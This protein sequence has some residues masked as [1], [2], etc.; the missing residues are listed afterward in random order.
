[1]RKVAVLIF[2]LFLAVFSG[3]ALLG[4]GGGNNSTT[5]P[6]P[7][8]SVNVIP[9]SLSLTPGQVAAVTARPLDADGNA[10]FANSVTFASANTALVQV[11]KNGL[12]CAGSWDS[13]DS[14]VVCTPAASPVGQTTITATADMVT[15]A[16]VPV[17][18]HVVIDNITV[19]PTAVDCR[20]QDDTQ[21][22]TATVF[23]GG[24]DITSTVGP[25]TWSSSLTPQ[26]TIDEDGLATAELPGRSNITASVGGTTSPAAPFTVCPPASISLHVSGAPDTS[27][28]IAT[29]ANRDLAVDVVDTLGQTVTGLPIALVSSSPAVATVSVA[30]SGS[31]VTLRATGAAP[32]TAILTAHC[33]PPAC[34][35]NTT[36]A[37]YSNAVTATVT[38]TAGAGRVYATCTSTSAPCTT[39][40]S[41]GGTQTPLVPIDTST[42]TA[43]TVVNLP[44]TP[45][46]MVFSRDGTLMLLG[47]AN[48]LMQVDA[49]TN[50]IADTITNAQGRVLAVSPDAN[51]V[52]IFDGSANQLRI[53]DRNASTVT[54]ASFTGITGAAFTPDGFKLFLVAGNTLHVISDVSVPQAIPLSAAAADLTMVPG[55]S[56]LYL[57]GGAASSVTAHATCDN[58]PAVTA[59]TPGDPSLIRTLP[60]G[61][62]VLAVDSPGIDD[63]TVVPTFSGPCPYSLSSVVTSSDFGQ[64]GFS[65]RQLI[66]LPDG[67]RAYVTSDLTSLLVYDVAGQTVTTIPL[68]N[69]ATA[70][71]GG[72]TLTSSQVYVGG[73]D[74]AVHRIDVATGIDAQQIPVTNGQSP[75]VAFTPD[76]VGVRP[77]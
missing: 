16:A 71:N 41:S 76:L 13:L 68:A 39:A 62:R 1:M 63:V 11:A 67:S 19:S 57:A 33:T 3:V 38:G 59:A 51:R 44:N 37:T 28:S 56:F 43:G 36:L 31:T 34:N 77:R 27:F 53:L 30:I 60:N 7:I 24:N 52:A 46:S 72:S 66:I 64:G 61:S 40:T 50:G 73:S 47:S 15:S 10:T 75:A 4:C 21:Q 26:V 32:G 6:N 42:N 2:F 5:T 29:S 70:F 58:S 65:A 18:V 17:F 20:S 35:P 49:V 9:S 25:I 55:G 12:V 45:N 48:G 22:F 54:S 69:G 14:P 74:D 23:G 8:A